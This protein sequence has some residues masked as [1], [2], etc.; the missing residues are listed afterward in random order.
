MNRTLH[1][2]A[3]Q[4]ARAQLRPS[5][6]A[7]LAAEARLATIAFK[8]RYIVECFDRN[9]NLKWREDIFNLVHNAGLDDL[10]DKYF[11]GS[12]YTAAW[13]IGLKGSGTIAA[14]DTMSSHAG[15]SEYTN[16]SESNRQTLTLGSVSGQAVNNSASK[17]VFNING[18][19]GTVAGA[20]IATNNTKGGTTGTLFGTADFSASRTVVSGDILNVQINLSAASA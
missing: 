20:F 11:K 16:Y 1:R 2:G 9:G 13:Y 14:G 7:E 18:A 12:T 10:L 15:W 3:A 5:S 4:V 19:G 6:V 8:N 17:G